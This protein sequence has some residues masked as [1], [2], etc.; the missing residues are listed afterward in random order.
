MFSAETFLLVVILSNISNDYVHI[1]QI[2]YYIYY[3]Y[4]LLWYPVFIVSC[5]LCTTF[6]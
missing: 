1:L 4:L 3:S 2:M 6:M 5:L